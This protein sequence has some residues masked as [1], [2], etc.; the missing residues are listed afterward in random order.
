MY[1]RGII[2]DAIVVGTGFFLALLLCGGLIVH[3]EID[4]G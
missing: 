2:D 3:E 4:K 1:N